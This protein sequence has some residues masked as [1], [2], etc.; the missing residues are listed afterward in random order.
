[1]VPVFRIRPLAL[2]AAEEVIPSNSFGFL[3]SDLLFVG[4]PDRL[5]LLPEED[6]LGFPVEDKEMG[7]TGPED[8]YDPLWKEF[9][10][11]SVLISRICP[12]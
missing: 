8:P 3:D 10:R 11:I 1:M 4:E 6:F 9:C 12:G 2:A 5:P 7:T